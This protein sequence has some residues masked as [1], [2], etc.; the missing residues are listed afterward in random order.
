VDTVPANRVGALA[1]AEVT[2]RAGANAGIITVSTIK[3][4][5]KFFWKNPTLSHD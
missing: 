5:L 1:T 4:L 3:I 2:K